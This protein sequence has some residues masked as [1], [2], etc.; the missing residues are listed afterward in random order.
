MAAI[1]PYIAELPLKASDVGAFR[2]VAGQVLRARVTAVQG[3]QA[4]FDFGYASLQVKLAPGTSLSVGERMLL[5]VT[6]VGPDRL[7]ISILPQ[8]APPGALPSPATSAD[9]LR[10]LG[11]PIDDP[12]LHLAQNLQ[13]QPAAS[14]IP[15]PILAALV[16]TFGAEASAMLP[17]IATLLKSGRGGSPESPPSAAAL[18]RNAMPTADLMQLLDEL[19]VLNTM[20]PSKE[21]TQRA[22]A[23]WQQIAQDPQQQLGL[24]LSALSGHGVRYHQGADGSWSLIVED[25]GHPHPEDPPVSRFLA[26]LD[27]PT[28]GAVSVQCLLSS[29]GCLARVT[30]SP[31]H[32][33]TLTLA[34]GVAE[35]RLAERL[36][37]PV[38]LT[39]QSGIAQDPLSLWL[40]EAP[41]ISRGQ[42]MGDQGSWVDTKA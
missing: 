21:Q 8:A 14:G 18:Q 9:L 29:A 26:K 37:R 30:A 42:P 28:L 34:L 2:L 27:M 38:H 17:R 15:T 6:E 22:V 20:E 19:L 36:G 3:T 5:Q 39:V 4:T 40:E 7:S 10:S 13:S 1:P 33:A 35:A 41:W 12:L 32:Q 11:F 23:A 16:L 24:A 31:A 25:K